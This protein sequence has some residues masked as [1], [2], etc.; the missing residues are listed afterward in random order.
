MKHSLDINDWN[1]FIYNKKLILINEIDKTNTLDSSLDSIKFNDILKD[2]ARSNV[3]NMSY[4]AFMT[5]KF[6]ETSFIPSVILLNTI[7]IYSDVE[8]YEILLLNDN[9]FNENVK[10]IKTMKFIINLIIDFVVTIELSLNIQCLLIT[11]FI[12]KIAKKNKQ[13]QDNDNDNDYDYNFKPRLFKLYNKTN[14]ATINNIK[15]STRILLFLKLI[16]KLG[17]NNMIDCNNKND[18]GN[19]NENEND[20]EKEFINLITNINSNDSELYSDSESGSSS[21]DTSTYTKKQ[22]FTYDD[23]GKIIKNKNTPINNNYLN[24]IHNKNEINKKT[25]MYLDSFMLD[26]TLYFGLCN[27]NKKDKDNSIYSICSN[28]ILNNTELIFNNFENIFSI[29][30][31]HLYKSMNMN[32]TKKHKLFCLRNVIKNIIDIELDNIKKLFCV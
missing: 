18:N 31:G 21:D 26:I 24:Y 30:E 28:Y 16:G 5:L 19:E 11:D 1:K 29:L 8:L 14:K 6:L 10:Y 13:N 2:I 25:K 32:S 22:N 15:P 7:N 12:D 17:I 23:T 27:S 20:N 9:Y 3:F 4:V